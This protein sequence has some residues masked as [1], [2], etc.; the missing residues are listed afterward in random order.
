MKSLLYIYL[1]CAITSAC[2][3]KLATEAVSDPLVESTPI[4][5][6]SSTV[7]GSM[8]PCIQRKIDSIKQQPAWNPPLQVNE[9]EYDGRK[10]YLFSANCCDQFESLLDAN[11]NYIC[12]PSGGFTGKGDRKCTDFGQQAKHLRLVWKDERARK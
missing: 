10:V 3:R 5:K 8:P 11:C 12:A 9:Y 6:S 2:H 4:E 1:A 7:A